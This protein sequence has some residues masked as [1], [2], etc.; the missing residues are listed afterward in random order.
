MQVEWLP[1]AIRDLQKLREFLR[2]KNPGAAKSAASKIIK[3]TSLFKDCP[4]VGKPVE[5][6]PGHYDVVIKFGF[7]NYVMRYHILEETIFI[8]ALRH[9]REAG[10]AIEE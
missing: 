9:G 4:G 3:A 6:L 2:P 10:F 1:G 8:E 7:R 5:D